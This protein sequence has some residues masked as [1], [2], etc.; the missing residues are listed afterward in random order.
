MNF[1]AKKVNLKTNKQKPNQPN[2]KNQTQTFSLEVL[3]FF[4]FHKET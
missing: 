2:E 4:T 3:Y 1:E